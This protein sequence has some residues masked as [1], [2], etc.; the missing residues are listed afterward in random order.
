M[1]PVWCATE[2]GLRWEESWDQPA[3]DAREARGV[4]KGGQ[5][6]NGIDILRDR[7]VRRLRAAGG[8]LTVGALLVGSA[9]AQRIERIEIDLGTFG[10]N[11]LASLNPSLVYRPVDDFGVR[12][13]GD[14]L[15]LGGAYLARAR[16]AQAIGWTPAGIVEGE[17]VSLYVDGYSVRSSGEATGFPLA[18]DI[19]GSGSIFTSGYSQNLKGGMK[20][21]MVAASAP[22]WESGE[23]RLVGGLSWRR[24]VNT[25]YPEETVSDFIFEGVGGFPV[26]ITLDR[27]ERGAIEAVAP[28]LGYR[29][30]RMLSVGVN[31]N[32]L[33]GRLRASTENRVNAGA[34]IPA[35]LQRI[36]FKYEGFAA[37]LGARAALDNL[38]M[39]IAV[40]ARFTPAYTVRVRGGDFRNES[41]AAPGAPQVLIDGKLAGYDMD[42]PASFSVGA[43][44]KVS[45]RLAVVADLNQHNWSE[46]KL[47]Y[48]QAGLES[49]LGRPTLPLRDV[50]TVNVGAEY[51]LLSRSWGDL[52][53]RAGFRTAPQSFSALDS[54][55]V[56]SLDGDA[57]FEGSE[58]IEGNAWSAGASLVTGNVSFDLGFERLSYDLSKLYF[59]SPRGS[60]TNPDG[61]IVDVKRQIRTVRFSATYRI[62]SDER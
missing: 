39:P 48:S 32:Y 2:P 53:I 33:T 50:S 28:T 40:A 23:S 16:G 19:P 1:E 20:P 55:D 47:S 30:N 21:G 45:P 11:E 36:S 22:L 4:R 46:T 56:S 42:I 14:A 58:Q 10:F 49:Q 52:P 44:L 38:P 43:E 17:G 7:W 60:F 27:Q 26:V 62:G 59:D 41:L 35:G 37:D 25:A 15:G 57:L 54:T 34:P 51:L 3:A 5:V 31:L 12:P 18:L 13:G 24:Y 61:A 9:A 8:A 29:L 6:R